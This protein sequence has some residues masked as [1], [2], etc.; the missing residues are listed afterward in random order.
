MTNKDIDKI[1]ILPS[2][3]SKRSKI[4]EYILSDEEM[5]AILNQGVDYAIKE[6]TKR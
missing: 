6:N 3:E 2:K 5:R 1:L 4:K